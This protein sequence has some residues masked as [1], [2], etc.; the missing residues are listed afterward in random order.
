MKG[1][2]NIKCTFKECLAYYDGEN[3]LFFEGNV[4]GKLSTKIIGNDID[5]NWSDLWYIFIPNNYNR[6]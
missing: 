5:N 1:I 2:K 3:L 6:L 4:E